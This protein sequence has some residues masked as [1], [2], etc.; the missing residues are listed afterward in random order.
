[1]R[2]LLL[3]TSM[4]L[5]MLMTLMTLVLLPLVMLVRLLHVLLHLM[6][7][8]DAYADHRRH[9]HLSARHL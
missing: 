9:P 1:L 5:V 2:L 6:L 7:P 4:S 8:T 3:V